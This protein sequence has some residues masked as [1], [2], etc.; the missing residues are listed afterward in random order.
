MLLDGNR[1]NDDEDD[2]VFFDVNQQKSVYSCLII[3]IE[4]WDK[5]RKNSEKPPYFSNIFILSG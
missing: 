2:F 5:E 1:Y 4:G 3:A